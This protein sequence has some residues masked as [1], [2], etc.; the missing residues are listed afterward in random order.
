MKCRF[1]HY[2]YKEIYKE[3]ENKYNKITR[4]GGS[5]FTGFTIS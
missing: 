2:N 3:D 1:E 4:N 5:Y